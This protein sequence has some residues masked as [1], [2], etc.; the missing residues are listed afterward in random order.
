MS[1]HTRRHFLVATGTGAAAVAGAVAVPSII[2][3]SG[4]HPAESAAAA[5]SAGSARTFVAFVS[6]AASGEVTLYAGNQER[7]V[8][9]RALVAR[10]SRHADAD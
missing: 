1:E 8:H 10:L 6:D 3:H 7:V 4:S 2:G 5:P 9:D